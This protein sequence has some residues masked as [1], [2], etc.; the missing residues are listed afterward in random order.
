MQRESKWLGHNQCILAPVSLSNHPGTFQVSEGLDFA[1]N[2]GRG[3]IITGLPYPPRMDARVKLKM[4]FLDETRKVSNTVSCF[5]SCLKVFLTYYDLFYFL[6]IYLFIHT[7][8]KGFQLT[9][10]SN[11]M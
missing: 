7:M 4:Q 5:V 8:S 11:K 2:N 10:S 6:F 9:L 3:V 1:D